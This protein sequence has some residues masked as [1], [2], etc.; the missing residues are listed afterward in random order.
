MLFLV[1]LLTLA[2]GLNGQ[3]EDKKSNFDWFQIIFQN[4]PVSNTVNWPQEFELDKSVATALR[5]K[6]DRFIEI[7]DITESIS[8]SSGIIITWVVPCI[9]NLYQSDKWPN[10][11][12]MLLHNPDYKMF[13]YPDFFHRNSLSDS[14]SIGGD[15][16]DKR[17]T[18]NVSS[19][20]FDLAYY[21][22][23]TSQC[24]LDFA[25]FPFDK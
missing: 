25:T 5:L 10:K 13:W 11:E 17:M 18:I 24:N 20:T 9:A 2:S 21:G 19:G 4:C 12:S 23:L 1:C 22:R 3:V 7:D 16:S 6:V 15:S 14:L 8:I